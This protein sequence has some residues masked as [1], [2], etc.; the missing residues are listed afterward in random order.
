MPELRGSELERHGKEVFTRMGLTCVYP[1]NQVRL[2]DLSPEGPYSSE[3]HLEFDYII[4]YQNVC[5][6]GEITGRSSLSSIRRKYRSFKRWYD[7]VSHKTI[8][9]DL[10]TVLG[11][12]TDK[13][14]PFR[15]VSEFR[16]FF[17]TTCFQRFDV[18]LQ[19]VSGVA[20]FFESD[21]RLLEEYSECIGEYALFPFLDVF[22][23]IEQSPRRPWELSETRHSLMRTPDIK[24]ASGDIGLAD[25]YTFEASPYEFLPIARVYRR[26]ML[27]D[28]TSAS[29]KNYQ[30]PLIPKKLIAIRENLLIDRDFM[31]PNNILVVLS[32][33]C[34]Y[35][36]ATR[37]L[38][39][40]DV[41]GTISVIDGQHR[42]FSYA[43]ENV[44]Q[45][46]GDT[47]KIMVTAIQFR[48]SDSDAVRR[49]SAR[50][51]IEINTNQTA[52]R[53]TH[54]DAIAYEILGET[55]PR[56]IAAHIILEINKRETGKLYGLFSTN[57]NNSGV[58][59]PTTVITTLK[60][61]TRLDYIRELPNSRHQVRVRRKQG[62]E[63]LFGASITEL[64]DVSVL[65]QC[66]IRCL[67][68]YF[69]RVAY[70]FQHDWP[71]RDQPRNT[72]LEYAKMIAAFIRLLWEFISEGLTWDSIQSELEQIRTNIMS[73]RGIKSYDAILFDPSDPKIPNAQPSVSD[74]YRFLSANRQNDTPIQDVI[75]R[76]R[77]SH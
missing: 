11:V 58:I 77:R 45:Q 7:I 34:N 22:G 49:Y 62:Y 52:I 51:F 70:V 19:D 32:N 66:G 1:L 37:T 15:D 23:P 16:G 59:Q 4:P 18:S 71:Q 29:S 76:R 10:L 40:P 73:L 38:R 39:I 42:L 41:Y 65:V 17:I 56:A 31:F 21:W 47:C 72:S 30:R 50:E 43:D 33:E 44:H 68:Q 12:S 53:T 54:L 28:L 48:D 64:A 46:L 26:D 6:I 67:E 75:S 13:I 74:D 25:I 60:M 35:N 61:L 14:R 8:N 55:H 27:P 63:S 24:I 9:E 2:R 69:N 57:Q 5:L 36:S 20:L 3:E